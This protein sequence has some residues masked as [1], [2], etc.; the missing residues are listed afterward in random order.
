[1]KSHVLPSRALQLRE[2]FDG[3]DVDRSGSIDVAELTEA[4]EYVAKASSR[5]NNA[6][7]D[8]LFR[9]PQKIVRF[10]AAM[11]TD[12]DGSVDFR[13]FLLA[14]THE[15]SDDGRR[16]H[17]S[18]NNSSHSNGN[19]NTSSSA[20]QTAR[21][22]NAFFEFA[23]K[24]QRQ[25]IMDFVQSGAHTDQQKYREMKKLFQIKYF[26]SEPSADVVS[27]S[28]QL[29]QVKQ[30][31]QRQARAIRSDAYRRQRLRETTRAR[32]AALF[33]AS[34]NNNNDNRN[35]FA[36]SFAPSILCASANTETEIARRKAQQHTRTAEK[37]VRQR[38][39]AFSL[40]DHHTFTPPVES[41]RE[42]MRPEN[43][44]RAAKEEA[45]AAKNDKYLAKN[46]PPILPP[47]SMRQ[48]LTA[49]EQGQR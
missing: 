44:R 36:E 38:F 17:G 15:S 3:L 41:V 6:Q 1:M 5:G 7:N 25:K 24:H 20:E 11:D 34:N 22:Q 27:V 32:E 31:V 18:G 4:I 19:N 42:A 49:S 26:K 46:V 29:Q 12:G 30:D 13:E 23:N 43:V 9:D 48:R 35:P 47:V 37:R 39:A 2:I 10:F 28:E 21:M 40:H 33:F 16:S 14:M 45:L 8:P